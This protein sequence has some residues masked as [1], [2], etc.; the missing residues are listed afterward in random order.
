MD[1]KQVD[2]NPNPKPNRKKDP[3]TKRVSR[4]YLHGVDREINY[5]RFSVR[6]ALRYVMEWRKNE[7][8]NERTE[9]GLDLL[10]EK[11]VNIDLSL[12]SATQMKDFYD[13]N[14]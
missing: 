1:T 12:E 10:M 8:I 3:E 5:S 9:R 7:K 13:V 4:L 14:L 11:L 6:V 2:P